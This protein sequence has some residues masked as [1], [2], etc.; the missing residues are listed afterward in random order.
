[1]EQSFPLQPST[2][3]H[4]LKENHLVSKSVSELGVI[5]TILLPSQSE[6]TPK[7]LK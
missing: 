3:R 4:N 6:H 1:M 7:A 5:K 2:S